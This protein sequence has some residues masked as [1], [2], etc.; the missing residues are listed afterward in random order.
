[1]ITIPATWLSGSILNNITTPKEDYV[2]IRIR[3]NGIGFENDH[4]AQIFNIV[5]RLHQRSEFKGTRVVL[6][7]GICI[8]ENRYGDLLQATILKSSA[9]F[10]LFFLFVT[11][12]Q[13]EKKEPVEDSFCELAGTRTQ[14]PYIKS[15][16]LYQ[17]SYRIVPLF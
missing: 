10:L 3:G 6:A 11:K 17:L 5:Q 2:D 9:G 1:M 13:N 4:A 12:R 8:I 15:V 14:G 16:L 7:L